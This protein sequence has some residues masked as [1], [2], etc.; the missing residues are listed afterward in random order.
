MI[1][2][3]AFD[4]I[5]KPVPKQSTRF[6]GQR[7]YPDPRVEAWQAAVTMA[8]KQAVNQ[9]PWEVLS[10]SVAVNLE[11]RLP[12]RRRRDLD[13][14]TKA[15]LDGCNKVIFED[16]TQVGELH[17]WKKVDRER[18]GVFVW[19]HPMELNNDQDKN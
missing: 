18:P 2:G 9:I 8:A 11:F 16:D 6:S 1:G 17:I 13:N 7:A 5:G 14:L 4:V 3:I 19:V 12:D 10:G 15:V